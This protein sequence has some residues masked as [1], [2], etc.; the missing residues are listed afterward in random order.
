MPDFGETLLAYAQPALKLHSGHQDIDLQRE[1]MFLVL[2]T[3]NA[4]I[5]ESLGDLTVLK[6]AKRKL[7]TGS[8]RLSE[9]VDRLAERKRRLYAG[10]QRLYVDFE[11]AYDDAGELSFHVQEEDASKA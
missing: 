11:L 8:A 2:T 4:V 1:L 3:W 6:E 7:A 10:D 9:M 5:F